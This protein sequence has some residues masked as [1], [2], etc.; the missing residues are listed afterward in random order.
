MITDKKN[1]IISIDMLSLCQEHSYKDFCN[2]SLNSFMLWKSEDRRSTVN[3][4]SSYYIVFF[5]TFSIQQHYQTLKNMKTSKMA[6]KKYIDF[7]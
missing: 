5:C 1:Y 2:W 3:F 6:K 7:I 4:P